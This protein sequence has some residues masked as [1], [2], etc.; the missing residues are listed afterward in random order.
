MPTQEYA[1][2]VI[3]KGVV[4]KVT[5]SV[6]EGAQDADVIFLCVPVGSLEMYIKRLSGAA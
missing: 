4:D 5:L 2:Q 3:A 6:E 1:D